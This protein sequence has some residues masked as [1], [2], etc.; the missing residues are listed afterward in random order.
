M[1]NVFWGWV[2]ETL[3]ALRRCQINYIKTPR[4]VAENLIFNEAADD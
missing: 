2:A 3:R 4:K 1:E